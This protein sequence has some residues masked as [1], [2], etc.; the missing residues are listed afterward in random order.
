[1]DHT[2][3]FG[4]IGTHNIV[5]SCLP[6]G[7]Y[8]TNA[9]S[10]VATTLRRKFSCIRFGLLVGIGGGVPSS[11][12]DIRLGDVVVSTPTGSFGGV[13]QYDMGKLTPHGFVRT[14]S[15]N[16]PPQVLLNAVSTMMSRNYLG[17]DRISENLVVFDMLPTFSRENA[18]PDILYE[19]GTPKVRP[20]RNSTNPSIHYGTIAS[21]N[22]VIKDSSARDRISRELNG[23]LCFEMETAGLMNNFPCLVIRGISDYSDSHKTKNWQPYAAA[24]AAAYA[25]DLMS[26]IP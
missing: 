21:G 22:T 5:L 14:G 20:Q 23:V 13:I 25:K 16:S 2:Y 6:I 3:T 7:Q 11:D 24:V 10:A 15:L 17:V 4:R 12:A 26:V 19:G 1:D 8:G 9:A 18:G